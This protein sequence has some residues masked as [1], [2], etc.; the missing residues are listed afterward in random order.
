LSP[1][2]TRA[3]RRPA[4]RRDRCSTPSRGRSPWP[5]RRRA[6]GQS[7]H[8]VHVEGNA[9][10]AGDARDV[11]QR[12]HGADLRARRSDRHEG[13]FRRRARRTSSG[14]TRPSPSTG[15][16]VTAAPV[17][18]RSRQALSTE[19]CSTADVI[20]CRAPVPARMATPRMARLLASVAPE[21]KMT[22]VPD[23]PTR[24]ATWR[25]RPRV[26][27]EPPSRES[28][29]RTGCRCPPRGRAASRRARE[30]LQERSRRS[31][32]RPGRERR[33]RVH[34]DY[35]VF[36]TRKRK[37]PPSRVTSSSSWPVP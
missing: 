7:A 34:V 1:G 14:L 4:A 20:T 30:D 36:L 21:V 10:G 5:R 24:R 28:A 13:R 31:R 11:R 12:L 26:I 15:K 29:A 2:R 37:T 3:R 17:F 8:C 18:S 27:R 6:C 9:R 23:P 25:G 16:T 33:P 19:I 22:P 35:R 32:N